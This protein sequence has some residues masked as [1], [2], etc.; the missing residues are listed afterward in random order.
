M[1]SQN[2]QDEGNVE[3][4]LAEEVMNVDEE[5]RSTR[6]RKARV[7]TAT[8]TKAAA[9]KWVPPVVTRVP[10]PS[11]SLTVA[12]TS[13]PYNRDAYSKT[14]FTTW[15]DTANHKVCGSLPRMSK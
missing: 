10:N 2:E 14:D 13:Y 5:T 4:V 8:P 11:L 1:D 9:P 6:S 12:N 7:A 15:P 3:E